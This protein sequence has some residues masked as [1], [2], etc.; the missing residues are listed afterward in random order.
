[1]FAPSS[2]ATSG[3]LER[4]AQLSKRGS[5]DLSTYSGRSCRHRNHP[6]YRHGRSAHKYRVRLGSQARRFHRGCF[7]LENIAD[8]GLATW[9]QVH[10]ARLHLAQALSLERPHDSW[11]HERPPG[12]TRF[13]ILFGGL[14]TC[15]S[16]GNFYGHRIWHSNQSYPARSWECNRNY[17]KRGTCRPPRFYEKLLKVLLAAHL[18]ELVREDPT[19]LGMTANAMEAAGG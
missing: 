6:H 5:V 7:I 10:D 17:R 15:E 13:S 1:M 14:I 11:E 16:C 8:L 12:A 2:A 19:V 9:P 18:R 3:A 4:Y